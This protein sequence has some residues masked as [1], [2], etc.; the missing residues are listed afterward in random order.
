MEMQKITKK[1]QIGE[2]DAVKMPVTELEKSE[3]HPKDDNTDS[4]VSDGQFA[5]SRAFND[6]I[7]NT[8]ESLIILMDRE[9]LIIRFNYA[10]ERAAGYSSEEMI[11]RH[12]WAVLSAN[13]AKARERIANLLAGKVSSTQ[14]GLCNQRSVYSKDMPLQRGGVIFD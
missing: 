3:K 12:L 11:G 13:Q 5:A 14:G 4:Q 8:A 1:Q 9:G 10:C 2:T 6:A 7:L